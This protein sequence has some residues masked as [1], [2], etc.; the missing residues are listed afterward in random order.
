MPDVSLVPIVKQIRIATGCALAEAKA[1]AQAAVA[2]GLG[3]PGLTRESLERALDN[4]GV[5]LPTFIPD[6]AARLLAL[7]PDTTDVGSDPVGNLRV[8]LHEAT[9]LG[10]H[11]LVPLPGETG[12]AQLTVLDLRRLLEQIEG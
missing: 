12:G 6:A 9:R 11:A 4:A 10:D 2:A 8:W 5:L 7:F 3:M 1:A